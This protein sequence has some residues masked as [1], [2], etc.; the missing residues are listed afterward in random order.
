MENTVPSSST[1]KYFKSYWPLVLMIIVIMCYVVIGYTKFVITPKA[2][3][4]HPT[5]Q[6]NVDIVFNTIA[7]VTILFV[8]VVWWNSIF[9]KMFSSGKGIF[10]T[11]LFFAIL[12]Q[13]IGFILNI[14]TISGIGNYD[15]TNSTYL[16]L[17][18]T[19]LFIMVVA[20]IIY[21]ILVMGIVDEIN[22]TSST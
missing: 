16:V 3:E 9:S 6:D 2:G 15:S 8:V 10:I 11:L 22:I 4:I 19:Q 21:V 5:T 1:T 17:K 7:L 12:L 14:L 13:F 20:I 18:S